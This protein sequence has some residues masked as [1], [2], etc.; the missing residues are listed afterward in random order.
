MYIYIHVYITTYV[1]YVCARAKIF[2][3]KKLDKKIRKGK[4]AKRNK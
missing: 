1:T 2:K 4:K 3:C